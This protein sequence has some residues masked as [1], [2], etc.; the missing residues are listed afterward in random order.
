M[1][2][3]TAS[4][5]VPATPPPG[6][7]NQPPAQ[8]SSTPVVSTTQTPGTP[9]ASSYGASTYTATPYN[10]DPESTV[11]S[12]IEHIISSGSPLM[13]QA[14]AKA[15]ETMNSRGLMNSSQAVSAGQV[16]LMDR[17]LPIA[18]QDSQSLVTAGFK[19]SEAGNIASQF[20]AGQ[21]NQAA[22]TQVTQQNSLQQTRMNNESA[23]AIQN[24][25][26]EGNLKNIMAQGVIN[27]ELLALQ[28]DNKLQLQQSAGAA[29]LY[30]QAL[31]YMS[32]IT[33]NP[34]LDSN[35]KTQAL[36][37][38]V[39]QI[40]DALNIMSTINGLPQVS[41]LLTFY[42]QLPDKKTPDAVWPPPGGVPDSGGG[43]FLG[44]F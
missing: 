3:P 37:N 22:N 10:V 4:V 23:I 44:M 31:A 26:N 42:G 5:A 35:Q 24:L 16:G 34:D 29:Q 11:A 13:Q 21:Q 27:K 39:I 30:S 38:S 28:N 14:E 25:Q 20:N 18:Q 41:S 19:T 12:Q 8:T 32:S 15:R 40:Q 33:T 6:L 36:N 2:D 1:A 7:M 9:T 17:A 43:G